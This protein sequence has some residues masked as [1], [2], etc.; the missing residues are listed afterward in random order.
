[1]RAKDWIIQNI[2]PTGYVCIPCFNNKY[3]EQKLVASFPSSEPL[4]ATA[5]ASYKMKICNKLNVNFQP[6]GNSSAA[7]DLRQ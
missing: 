6:R 5:S 4:Y 7:A 3:P 2:D 1:M